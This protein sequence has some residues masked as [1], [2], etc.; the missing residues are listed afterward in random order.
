MPRQEIM[1]PFENKDIINIGLIGYLQPVCKK[2]LPVLYIIC[3]F[4]KFLWMD[5]V[6]FHQVLKGLS[7]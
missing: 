2:N 1:E 7:F 3:T 4:P 6:L 5:A